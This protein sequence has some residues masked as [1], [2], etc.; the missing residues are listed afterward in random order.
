MKKWKVTYTQLFPTKSTISGS[1]TI[2]AES[3][4]EA[5]AKAQRA[6]MAKAIELKVDSFRL[7]ISEVIE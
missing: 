5:K 7:N 6:M 2:E 4:D 3:E 1:F